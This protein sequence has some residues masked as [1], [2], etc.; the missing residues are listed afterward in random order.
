[1]L[2]GLSEV[3]RRFFLT[4]STHFDL[5][6]FRRENVYTAV[7]VIFLESISKTRGF[8]VNYT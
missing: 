8:I 5:K 2:V 1:V 7:F 6:N 4:G 3:F